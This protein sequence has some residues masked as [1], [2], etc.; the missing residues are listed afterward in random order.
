MEASWASSASRAS[1]T[2]RSISPRVRA[3]RLEMALHPLVL[4]RRLLEVLLARE[5][6]GLARAHGLVE[7]CDALP[8]PRHLRPE[9]GR[10]RL[11][12]LD[13]R[14]EPAHLDLELTELALAR[15]QRVLH[16]RRRGGAAPVEPA[17]R[18]QDLARGRDVG[19]HHAVAPPERLR[20]IEVLDDRHLAEE[21]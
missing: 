7:P 21:V 17:R 11:R 16:V 14:R 9:R 10:A 8:R 20:L 2:R 13:L 6:F 4:A 19:R 5:S 15:E 12:P 1:R 18:A 3:H